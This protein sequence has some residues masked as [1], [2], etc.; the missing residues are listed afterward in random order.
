MAE[1]KPITSASADNA[2]LILRYVFTVIGTIMLSQQIISQEVYDRY[3]KGIPEFVALV[4]VLAPFIQSIWSKWRNRQKTEQAVDVALTLPATATKAD[5]IAEIAK[6]P[7]LPV[8]PKIT[9]GG[10]TP[11]PLILLVIAAVV[12]GGVAITFTGCSYFRGGSSLGDVLDPSKITQNDARKALTRIQEVRVAALKTFAV[13]YVT[14]PSNAD[15]IA[16]KFAIDGYDAEF[17]KHWGN[18]ALAVDAWTPTVFVR[19]YTS[20]QEAVAAMKSATPK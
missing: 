10:K 12:L 18:A 16:A 13:V 8:L 19:E 1:E 5:V 7:A 6:Q 2:G 17:R 15:L 3:I 20:A 11:L 9:S 4:L 14:A